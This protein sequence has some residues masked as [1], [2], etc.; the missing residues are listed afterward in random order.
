M[1]IV[2]IAIAAACLAPLSG[3]SQEEQKPE[4]N[5]EERKAS[6]AIIE[7]HISD[8]KERMTEIANE[9]ITLDRRLEGKLD[10]VV[11]RLASISDSEKSGYR[12]G[13]IKMNAMKGLKKTIENYQ[14]KRA[15]LMNKINQGGS[16]IPKEVLEGDAKAFDERI[17]KRVEQILEISKSFTQEEDVKKYEEVEGTGGYGWGWGPAT[18]I[19]DDYR[20]NRRNRN[21]NKEQ[22]TEMMEALKKS[23]ERHESLV[24]SLKNRL[25]NRKMSDADRE[26]LEAEMARNVSLLA[27]RKSQ[28]EELTLVSQPSTAELN[29]DAALDLQD[30]LRDAAEDMRQDFETIFVKYAQLNRERSKLFKLET[31]LEARKKWLADYE[32]GKTK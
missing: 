11:K 4:I 28:L 16:G 15:S 19:S 20:Q 17:E 29:R 9:I 14:S 21:M 27:T 24:A 5:I 13:Q 10:K 8:R 22:R 25:E 12:V 2:T 1:R 3:W 26:L 30:A 23:I 32:A 6:I 18:R 7:D 31:N